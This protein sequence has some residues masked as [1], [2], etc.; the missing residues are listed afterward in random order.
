MLEMLDVS[1][2]YEEKNFKNV[3]ILY[4]RYCIKNL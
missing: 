4:P 1:S 2:L 3:Y